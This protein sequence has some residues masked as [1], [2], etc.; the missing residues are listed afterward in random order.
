[1]ADPPD[2]SARVLRGAP[3]SGNVGVTVPKLHA[4]WGVAVGAAATDTGVGGAFVAVG[5]MTMA[6]VAVRVGCAGVTVGS[7]VTVA[8]SGVV[9]TGM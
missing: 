6:R 7:G 4:G 2:P 1:M 5:R 9:V 8:G 3:S